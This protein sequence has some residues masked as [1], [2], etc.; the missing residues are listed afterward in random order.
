MQYNFAVATA[1][2]RATLERERLRRHVYLGRYMHQDVAS[3]ADME[4]TTLRAYVE[5]L[6]ECIREENPV[7]TNREN[8]W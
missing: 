6:A 1:Y 3:L 7:S 2:D 4:M 5:I 8:N